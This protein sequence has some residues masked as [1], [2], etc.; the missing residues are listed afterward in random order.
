MESHF[1]AKLLQTELHA[2]LFVRGVDADET[3]SYVYLSVRLDELDAFL[4]AQ[5]KGRV[6]LN[7]YGHILAQGQGSPDPDTVV[8]METEYGF[9]H[10][11]YILVRPP[12]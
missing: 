8:R 2:I 3:P 1:T 12:A 11:D 10:W 5:K 9:N 4:T 6:E 7:H